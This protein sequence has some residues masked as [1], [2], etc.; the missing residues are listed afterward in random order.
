MSINFQLTEKLNGQFNQLRARCLLQLLRIIYLFIVQF[1]LL[2][3]YFHFCGFDTFHTYL[4]L[5]LSSLFLFGVGPFRFK[6]S[7]QS[8]LCCIY[9]H[10]SS[11]HVLGNGCPPRSLWLSFAFLTNK[12]SACSCLLQ[13]DLYNPSLYSNLIIR[14]NLIIYS[15][16]VQVSY[17]HIE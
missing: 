6:A 5:L 4:L 13:H 17:T 9:I 12:D 14:I 7:R 10:L 11:F 8:V 3:C 2:R 15:K 16:C 1:S